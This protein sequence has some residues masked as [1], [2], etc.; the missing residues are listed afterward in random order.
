MNGL[1]TIAGAGC[2]VAGVVP[3]VVTCTWAATT[4]PITAFTAAH[5][6][7]VLSDTGATDISVITV[8][9]D[10]TGAST[11]GVKRIVQTFLDDDPG[12][13]TLYTVHTTTSAAANGAP[14]DTVIYKSWNYDSGDVLNTTLVPGST[15]AQWEAAN[16]ALTD[17]TAVV[18]M[19][20]RTGAATTGVSVFTVN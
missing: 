15:E 12:T 6:S 2:T 3:T 7:P 10:G 16:A 13:N 19:S 8:L 4:G 5:G 17:N 9:Q 1:S 18:T 20:Y 14:A 11:L